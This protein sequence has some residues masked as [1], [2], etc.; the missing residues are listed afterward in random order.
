MAIIKERPILFSAPMVRSILDGTKTQTRRI[1]KPQ[2]PE[3]PVPN[4][5][6][7]HKQKHAA[8]YLDAYCGGQ[9]TEKNPRG[10]SGEW[11]WWQV[12]DQACPPNF[13]C[14]FGVPGDRLWVRE[15]WAKTTNVDG[16]MDWPGRPHIRLKDADDGDEPFEAIIYRADGEWEWCD[17]DGFRS[18]KS[19]WRPSIYM[20]RAASRILL[21]ITDIR[22][23]RLQDITED[24]AVAEGL[25]IFKEGDGNLYYSALSDDWFGDFEKWHLDPRDAYHALWESINGPD[26]WDA[27]PFVWVLNLRNISDDQSDD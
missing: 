17:G 12:D 26:S 16:Q 14:K 5:H 22:V 13:K 21:E 27:S 24:D 2:P 25:H 7:S 11:C 19:Y 10:H 23:E 3:M 20:P 4:C 15:T 8:P 6:P 18:G 9:R 1:I